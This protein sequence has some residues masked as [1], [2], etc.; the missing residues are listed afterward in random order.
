[1]AVGTI[2]YCVAEVRATSGDAVVRVYVAPVDEIAC[3]A[4]IGS[5]EPNVTVSAACWLSVTT[6]PPEL[7]LL[8]TAH[9]GAAI[10]NVKIAAAATVTATVVRVDV[11]MNVNVV[12]LAVAVTLAPIT[13][14]ELSV[15]SSVA[16][17]VV[18]SVTS[19][20]VVAPDANAPKFP[21]IVAFEL[22]KVNDVRVALY[23]TSA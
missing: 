2:V 6:E 3:V 9:V 12:E 11:N 4:P 16:V 23:A 18:A 10:G 5:A 20:L 13:L 15:A 7:P 21:L 8:T 22:P 14:L 1:M 17:A 19:E